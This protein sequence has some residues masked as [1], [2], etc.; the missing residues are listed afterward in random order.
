MTITRYRL[1]RALLTPLIRARRRGAAGEPPGAR[2]LLELHGYSAAAR[3]LMATKAID[4]DLL[5]RV[6][7]DASST[8]FDV[9]GYLGNGAADIHRLYGGRVYTFEPNP[10]VFEQLEQ[11]FAAEPAVT[12]LPFGLAAADATV[13]LALDGPGSSVQR[14][15]ASHAPT[16]EIQLRDVVRVIDELG[17]E[18]IDLMK[19]NIEGGE[20]D[21][22]DRLIESGAIDRV[23]YLLIQFHEWHDDHA[24]RRRRQIRRGLRATHDEVWDYSWIWELWCASDQPHPAPPE[25]DE[26]TRQ[27]IVA[28]LMRERAAT[29]TVSSPPDATT[30]PPG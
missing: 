20:Y 5:H 30:S 6:D 22:L 16:K 1:K 10:G 26:A 21:L 14:G 27:A 19:I 29:R 7:L 2:A 23:R 25:Y 3:R 15:A 24:H 8:T 4:P 9:G 18:R 11:R 28:E 12:A 13:R 17:G